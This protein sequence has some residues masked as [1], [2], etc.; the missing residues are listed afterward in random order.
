MLLAGVEGACKG[1][2]VP[3]RPPAVRVGKRADNDVVLPDDYVSR[4]HARIEIRDHNAVLIDEQSTNGS[5]VNDVQVRAA[6]LRD[7]DRVR[8]GNCVFQFRAEPA[9]VVVG[10]QEDLDLRG[11]HLRIAPVSLEEGPRLPTPAYASA[12]RALEALAELGRGAR[13]QASLP[14]VLDRILGA[15]FD[16][17]AVDRGAIVLLDDQ[18][19]LRPQSVRY[20]QGLEGSDDMPVSST[21]ARRA[22]GEGSAILVPDARIDPELSTRASIMTHGIC[23]AAYV[24]LLA[25]GQPVGLLCVDKGEAGALSEH[26]LEILGAMAGEAGALIEIAR[27]RDH[28]QRQTRVRARL[29]RYLA[30]QVVEELLAAGEDMDLEGREQQVTVL[31]ADLRGFTSLAERLAAAEAVGL[32]NAALETL[33]H[34]VFMHHG[35]LDKYIGDGLMALFGAPFADAQQVLRACM[36]ALDMHRTLAKT[37]SQWSDKYG[38]L[39][40]GAAVHTGKAVVGNIGTRERVQYTAIGDAVNVAA[41]LEELAGRNETLVSEEV[42][43]SVGHFFEFAPL[44]TQALRGRQGTVSVHRLIG[45]KAEAQ[46][47]AGE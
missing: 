3:L 37:A 26:H 7:G 1:M 45:P 8:F 31:F 5:F 27:L 29:E 30:S 2:A 9:A 47:P 36:A 43:Q 20:R 25:E 24:P 4:R 12:S 39:A 13:M 14:Q 41:R 33:T 17:V 21:L 44:G 18:G 23:C 10:E 16:A 6:A 28:V 34:V 38:E 19:Q 22:L 46:Q 35:T 32:L 11:T 15:V 42:A 40:I